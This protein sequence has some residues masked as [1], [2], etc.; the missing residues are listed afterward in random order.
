MGTA[1]FDFNV[2]PNRKDGHFIVL[3]GHLVLCLGKNKLYFMPC[4]QGYESLHW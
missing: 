2:I 1:R 4:T 3:L